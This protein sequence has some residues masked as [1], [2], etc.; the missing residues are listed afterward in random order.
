MGECRNCRWWDQETDDEPRD[1]GKAIGN[2][3]LAES[4]RSYADHP[5][6]LA[7]ALDYEGYGGRLLTTEDFGCV[8]FDAREGR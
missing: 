6:T 5:E 2:C 7:V 3:L 8:Q 4:S 1:D